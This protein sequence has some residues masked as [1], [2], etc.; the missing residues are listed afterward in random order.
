MKQ[1]IFIFVLL[2]CNAFCNTFA[3]D[4][5]G[6]ILDEQHNPIDYASVLLC[7][8]SDSSFVAGS[9]TDP[10]G[11]FYF[12]NLKEQQQYFLKVSCIG[13]KSKSISASV[14]SEMSITL[15]KDNHALGEIIIRGHRSYVKQEGNKTIFNLNNMLNVEGL[16]INDILKYAPRVT[17]NSD[18]DIKIAGKSAT[19]YV[20][21]RR[22]S[23]DETSTFLSGLN[24]TDVSKIEILQNNGGEKDANIRGGIINIITKQKQ[25]G[26]KGTLYVKASSPDKGYYAY[27]PVSNLYFGTE[28]WNVYGMYSYKQGREKQY[29]ITT[30]EYLHYNTKHEETSNYFSHVRNHYYRLGS[31]I[32]VSDRQH[33]ELEWNGTVQRPALNASEGMVTFCTPEGKTYDG[34]TFTLYQSRSD[35]MNIALSYQWNFDDKDGYLR[36]LLN[37][38]H[39]KDSSNNNLKASYPQYPANNVSEDDI[40]ASNA[41]SWSM[42]ADLQKNIGNSWVLKLGGNMSTCTRKSEYTSEN[43]GADDTNYTD[44]KYKEN[45]GAAYIGMSKDFSNHCF[46]KINVRGEYTDVTGTYEQQTSHNITKKYMDWFPYLYFSYTTN[47]NWKYDI[48]YSRSI[49]RPPFS[50]MNAYSNRMSDVLYDRGNPDLRAALT[51]KIALSANYMGHSVSASYSRTPK[52]IVEFFQVENGITYHTN[53]NEGV[54]STFL[55]DYSYSGNICSWWQTNLYVSSQ[56]TDLPHSYN[57]KHLW[58]GSLS[59]DNLLDWARIGTFSIDFGATT[60]TAMGNAYIRGNWALDISYKRN[61]LHKALSLQLGIDDVFDTQHQK[62]VNIVPTLKYCFYTE[63]QY[64]KV[65]CSLTYN[66]SSKAKVEKKRLLNSNNIKNRL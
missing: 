38:N 28:K 41:N 6:K 48:Q 3:Q 4:I 30:N 16:K 53:I 32:S 33:L 34:R 2:A 36:I 23:E 15:E 45:I 44:W 21:G 10:K 61:F 65:W 46:F 63:R 22:L 57:R 50:L 43:L 29:S 8:S 35:F 31:V 37:R 55:L 27:T 56:Y 49:Y 7:H 18:G 19:I 24:A 62:I 26:L 9:I 54:T 1:W 40:T 59:I 17:F 11:S 64:R 39:K 52:D 5:R 66:I 13:Y 51:D 58:G 47:K 20:N 60:H 25:L 14:L 42:N 12:K